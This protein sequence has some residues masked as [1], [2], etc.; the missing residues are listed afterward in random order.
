MW[1]LLFLSILALGTILERLWFW[2]RIVTREREVSGRVIEAA[3][4]EMARCHR[5]CPPFE[6]LAH[7]AVPLCSA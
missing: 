6:C 2:S 4:R 3:R 1:P 5:N 7:G